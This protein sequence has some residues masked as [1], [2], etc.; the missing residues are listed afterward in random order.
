MG[1]RKVSSYWTWCGYRFFPGWGGRR[2]KRAPLVGALLRS[3]GIQLSNQSTGMMESLTSQK[4]KVGCPWY[5][6]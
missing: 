4:K 3:T 5:H 1:D 6:S 2:S